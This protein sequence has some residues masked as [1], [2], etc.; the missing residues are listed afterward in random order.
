MF[1]FCR[2]FAERLIV[3]TVLLSMASGAVTPQAAASAYRT[4]DAVA[5]DKVHVEIAGQAMSDCEPVSSKAVVSVAE[6]SK[7]KIG[8]CR[9]HLCIGDYLSPARAELGFATKDRPAGIRPADNWTG[10]TPGY[11]PPPPKYD[12]S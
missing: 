4:A 12:L 7:C 9:L 6:P 1:G 10:I 3:V 8:R 11:V 2:C 5:A